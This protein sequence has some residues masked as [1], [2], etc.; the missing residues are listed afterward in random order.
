MELPQEEE[1]PVGQDLEVS[2]VTVV[3]QALVVL[4]QLE[5][6]DLKDLEVVMVSTVSMEQ[7]A[8]QVKEDLQAKRESKVLWVHLVH[9]VELVLAPLH[10]FG[11][12][13]LDHQTDQIILLIIHVSITALIAISDILAVV[14]RVMK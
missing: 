10:Y 1:I 12:Q 5:Q 3:T 11:V 9:Q 14:G 13:D 8:Q 7:E 4:G 2:R 6:L